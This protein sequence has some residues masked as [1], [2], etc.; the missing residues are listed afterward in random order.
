MFE[1][2]INKNPNFSK[3][4]EIKGEYLH[5]QVYDLLLELNGQE[6]VNYEEL[7]SIIRYDKCLRDKLYIYLATFEEY[8]RAYIFRNY[9]L[10][11]TP[12]EK[13]VPIDELVEITVK[14]L[15]NDNSKLYYYF[16]YDL[17]KTIS[18]LEQNNDELVKSYDLKSIRQ[19]RNHV[20]H[21][22]LVTIGNSK[23]VKEMFDNLKKLK[24]QILALKNAL[25]E[26]YRIG[27]INDINK[28]KCDN[29]E[30]KVKI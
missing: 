13:N 30:F 27:F 23:T 24:N 28:L 17:G 18:Y 15:E 6:E 29:K 2:L 25:P 10:T 20:M 7:S 12:K 22:N 16:N 8:I 14:N 5:K 4:I 9:D 1:K 26:D 3:F 19:L 11:E 21:H